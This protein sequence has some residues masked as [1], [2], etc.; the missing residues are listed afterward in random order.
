MAAS[1]KDLNQKSK[2]GKPASLMPPA[3]ARCRAARSTG[4]RSRTRKESCYRRSSAASVRL[5]SVNAVSVAQRLCVF[6]CEL[7][8]EGHS[9]L[10]AHRPYQSSER[11]GVSASLANQLANLSP[12]RAKLNCHPPHLFKG[13]QRDVFWMIHDQ[14]QSSDQPLFHQIFTAAHWFQCSVPVRPVPTF[15]T[16]IKPS[17]ASAGDERW[18]LGRIRKLVRLFAFRS[19]RGRAAS[20]WPPSHVLSWWKDKAPLSAQLALSQDS[21]NF[22]HD[23]EAGPSNQDAVRRPVQKYDMAL[24][25]RVNGHYGCRCSIESSGPSRTLRARV[26]FSHRCPR[27]G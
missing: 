7:Q 16:R 3:R 20:R 17:C 23:E 11:I 10:L 6:P 24:P 12:I 5:S 13:V 15:R 9:R 4:H 25:E 21:Y 27:E 2:M 19:Y 14:P 18:T 26:D 1:I 8:G 22:A